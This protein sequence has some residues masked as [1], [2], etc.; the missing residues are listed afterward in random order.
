MAAYDA[1]Y[2]QA[3]YNS[4]DEFWRNKQTTVVSAKVD[5]E[6]YAIFKY[7]DLRVLQ[8]FCRSL[9][10]YDLN[11]PS[12]FDTLIN[13]LYNFKKNPGLEPPDL[14]ALRDT[15]SQEFFLNQQQLKDRQE[16]AKLPPPEQAQAVKQWAEPIV[17]KNAQR[18]A[19]NIRNPIKVT[20]ERLGVSGKAGGLGL[21]T[22]ATNKPVYTKTPATNKTISTQTTTRTITSIRSSQGVTR[23]RPRGATQQTQTEASVTTGITTQGGSAPGGI[24]KSV[25]S[26]PVLS[27]V[28]GGLGDLVIGKGGRGANFVANTKDKLNNLRNRNRPV[29][30]A[31]QRLILIILVVVIL[32]ILFQL[33]LPQDN[34]NQLEIFKSGDSAVSN[35]QEINY[36]IRVTYTGTGSANAEVID[37]IPKN[38]QFVSASDGGVEVSAENLIRWNLN[39]LVSNQPKT[40]RLT[41]KPTSDDTW[42]VNEAQGRIISTT[43]TQTSTGGSQISSLLPSPLEPESPSLQRFKPEVL[44]SIN[45]YPEN[46]DIYK[47]A[48]Q[49]TSVPWEILSAI[50][51][52]EGSSNPNQSLVSGRAVGANEPDVVRTG[53]CSNSDT[54]P[55]KPIPTGDG[56]CKFNSLLDTAIY[57]GNHLKQKIGGIPQSFQ[58]IVTALAGYNGW[59]NT[60]CGKTPYTNCPPAFR[61]D[62]HP[63]PMNYFDS[64]H[65]PMYIVYCADLTPCAVPRVFE[66]L[67]IM[68]VVRAVSGK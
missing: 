43:N 9:S 68:A 29:V 53:S 16:I 6:I 52:I 38:A 57:A 25:L 32:F 10:E 4:I 26:N 42:L 59:G 66:R 46:I 28:A 33:F 13:V 58:D 22:A 14:K 40:I 7:Y 60:N 51:Y 1:K 2:F 17:S 37:P 55:G 48:E 23:I 63:Y 30:K 19:S 61:G 49:I 18:L 8:S 44:A 20:P 31:G 64:K 27:G 41:L 54:G 35:G 21:G 3:I 24:L 39:G 5:T 12:E 67:G 56:G 15:I 62:D 45:K 34:N 50:H 47:Q 11:N 36:T 65:E